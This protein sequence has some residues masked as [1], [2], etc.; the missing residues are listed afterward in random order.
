MGGPDNTQ[1]VEPFL[2]NLFRDPAIFPL[3]R[4][5]A[6]LVGALIAKRRHQ[7]VGRRYLMMDPQ[8][9]TPQ[10]PITQNQATELARLLEGA[11]QGGAMVPDVAMRYWNP[12]PA[13][14]VPS[15]LERGARQFV[16]VPTYPQYSSATGGS[17]LDLVMKSLK[18]LA[19]DSP[20][21][22]VSNWHNLDGYIADLAKHPTVQLL[23]WAHEGA[24]PSAC[25]LLYAAHSMPESFIRQGDPYEKLTRATVTLVHERVHKALTEAGHGTWLDK[26]PGDPHCPVAY[27]SKVG[28]IKW[29]GPELE[30]ECDRLGRAGCRKL[31]IQP[32]SFVCDNIETLVELD[33]ELKETAELAGVRDFERGP[34]LNMQAGWLQSMTEFISENAFGRKLT[35]AKVDHRG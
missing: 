13:E 34:A 15:L 30:K 4:L 20:V 11:L 32:V 2:R 9:A 14:T 21:Y 19:P 16:V 6:P 7:E 23:G 5:V 12:F 3:P 35:S 1:A 25:A 31:M 24:D 28:P 8:G 33:V 10:L 18:E 29:L 17:T 22:V 26:L 27:Q